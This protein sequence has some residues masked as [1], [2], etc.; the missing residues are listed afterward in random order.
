MQL[1]WLINFFNK[2]RTWKKGLQ[3]SIFK[4]CI[5]FLAEKSTNCLF[6]FFFKASRQPI[7]NKV[8]AEKFITEVLGLANRLALPQRIVDF[9]GT[10]PIYMA[11]EI[12]IDAINATFYKI[13]GKNTIGHLR[14]VIRSIF[15]P[16]YGYSLLVLLLLLPLPLPLPLPHHRGMDHS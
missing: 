4:C 15:R 16:K 12:P 9:C 3:R 7:P 14:L 2:L 1:L 11:K 10:F 5:I 6:N 8:S 13:Q